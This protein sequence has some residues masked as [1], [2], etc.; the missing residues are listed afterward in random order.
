ME[1]R[2]HLEVWYMDVRIILLGF[3]LDSSG[4]GQEPVEGCCEYGNELS[5]SIKC[6][7]FLNWGAISFTK[8]AVLHEVSQLYSQ[9]EK[10]EKTSELTL[11][12]YKWMHSSEILY[13]KK[14]TVFLN[15]TLWRPVEVYSCSSETVN[16]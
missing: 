10:K 2:D 15:L 6:L 11:L 16:F 5:Y 14:N 3:W 1:N 12:H 13:Y 9:R 7:E 4:S 8:M